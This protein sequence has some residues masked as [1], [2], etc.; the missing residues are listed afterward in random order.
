MTGCDGHF[1]ADMSMQFQRQGMQLVHLWEDVWRRNMELVERR[2]AVLLGRF[3]RYHAR[4]TKVRSI[5]NNVLKD[6]LRHHHLLPAI[7]GR[8]KYGLFQENEL[9]AAASFSGSCTMQRNGTACKSYELLRYASKSGCVVA[10]GLGKLI[11][12]FENAKKPDDI[13]TYIDADWGWGKGL[14]QLGFE[15]AGSRAPQRFWLDAAGQRQYSMDAANGSDRMVCWN[16]GS[17]KLVKYLVR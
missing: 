15:C 7:G 11:A 8:Y 4:K 6:F 2:M 14:R 3:V 17:I 5:D 10:G 9:L 12:H 13:M 16:S 1:F